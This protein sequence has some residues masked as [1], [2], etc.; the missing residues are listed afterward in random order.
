MIQPG[1][2]G[3][4]KSAWGDVNPDISTAAPKTPVDRN[5]STTYRTILRS[6]TIIMTIEMRAFT[7]PVHQGCSIVCASKLSGLRRSVSRPAFSSWTPTVRPSSRRTSTTF[8]QMVGT[9]LGTTALAEGI[10]GLC[11]NVWNYA[12]LVSEM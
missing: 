4:F 12:E 8:A 9:T 10:P 6:G 11:S 5:K 2:R 7:R 3:N 1:S